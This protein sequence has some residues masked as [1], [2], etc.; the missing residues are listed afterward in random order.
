VGTRGLVSQLASRVVGRWTEMLV[1]GLALEVG[2][3]TVTVQL[4]VQRAP[5][6]FLRLKHAE[7][8]VWAV[9]VVFGVRRPTP[10]SCNAAERPAPGYGLSRSA[11][12]AAA[13]TAT[14]TASLLPAGP[15]GPCLVLHAPCAPWPLPPPLPPPAGPPAAPAFGFD[16]SLPVVW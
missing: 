11:A 13:A 5:A 12:T 1:N 8:W 16:S 3:V 10:S 6:L 4:K 2:G 14:A 9:G 7:L 15:A